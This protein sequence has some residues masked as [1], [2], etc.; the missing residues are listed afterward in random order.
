MIP[1]L[2]TEACSELG[3][4]S[5]MGRGRIALAI[6]VRGYSLTIDRNP[7]PQPSPI[8]VGYI[9][10]RQIKMPNSGKPELGG[11][12]SSISTVVA[13]KQT[14]QLAQIGL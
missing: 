11:R 12:G 6:R 4:A 9:R 1:K 8:E 5:P 13:S 7:S 2:E 10:L 14:I 3:V